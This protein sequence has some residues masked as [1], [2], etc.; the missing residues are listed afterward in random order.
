MYF[1]PKVSHYAQILV[2]A[3]DMDVEVSQVRLAAVVP[4]PAMRRDVVLV[5]DRR[6]LPDPRRRR[7]V[8]VEA[9]QPDARP[10]RELA[11]VLRVTRLRLDRVVQVDVRRDADR[12]P[13]VDPGAIFL[14]A[15]HRDGVQGEE[16]VRRDGLDGLG[17]R[18][19]RGSGCEL[20]PVRQLRV[21]ARFFC[22]IARRNRADCKQKNLFVR[23]IGKTSRRTSHRILTDCE[24]ER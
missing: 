17:S 6:R 15:A 1:P 16:D 9:V 14:P 20:G 11:R 21:K 12:K 10:V 13:K 2:I 3:R 24:Q 5:A 23:L 18:D 8:E 4:S 19:E 7:A 22:V